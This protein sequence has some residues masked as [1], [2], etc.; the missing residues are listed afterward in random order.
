MDVP[1]RCTIVRAIEQ[2]AGPRTQSTKTHE[3]HSRSLVKE[4]KIASSLPYIKEK[5]S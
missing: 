3:T 4:C 2:S 1:S 5:L